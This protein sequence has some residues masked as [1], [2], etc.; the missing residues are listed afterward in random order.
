MKSA[1][2]IFAGLVFIAWY[3]LGGYPSIEAFGVFNDGLVGIY[4][5]FGDY[6][7]V[8]TLAPF[9]TEPYVYKYNGPIFPDNA[10]DGI[11]V[12]PTSGRLVS[13]FSIASYPTS[14]ACYVALDQ[15][16]ARDGSPVDHVAA[17]WWVDVQRVLA[18]G[19]Y[20]I[21]RMEPIKQFRDSVVQ[22]NHSVLY[23]CGGPANN[24]MV[25]RYLDSDMRQIFD[26]EVTDT[27]LPK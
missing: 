22:G 5:K 16:I 6:I 26:K 19:W 18:A 1:A 27:Q 25:I 17:S 14:Q 9:N 21:H 12:T 7:D 11:I 8:R 20:F 15:E 10:V 4:P 3:F 23:E 2:Q 24:I 13:T